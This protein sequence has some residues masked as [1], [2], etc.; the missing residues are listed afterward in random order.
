MSN[1][2]KY[3]HDYVYGDYF[4]EKLERKEKEILVIV[5]FSASFVPQNV[6]SF[7]NST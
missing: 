6:L 3:F 4:V 2:S 5:R 7:L 1:S